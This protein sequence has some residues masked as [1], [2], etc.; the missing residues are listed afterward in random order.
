MPHHRRIC[1]TSPT[2][3]GKSLMMREII[4]RLELPTVLY[5]NRRMLIEQLSTGM[6]DDGI[7]YGIRAAG[8]RPAFL[9]DVQISSLQTEHSRVV[10]RKSWSLHEAKLVMV[11][12]AHGQKQATAQEIL[13]RHVSAGAT[14]IGFTATP[15]DIGEMYDHLIVAGVNSELRACGAHV[16]CHTHAPDEPETKNL[17]RTPTGEYTEGDVK[18][19]IMTPTIVGRVFDWWKRLNPDARPAILFAPGVAESLYFAQ[20]FY[21]RGVPA[22]H[23]DGDEIWINGTLMPADKEARKELAQASESGEVKIVCNRFVMR[24]GIDWPWLYHC[25]MATVFGSLTSYLQS[26]GRLLRSHPSLDHVL[27]QD[28]GGNWWRHGSL[29]A[30]REWDL[31]QT[32]YI[33][34]SMREERI[35]EKKEPEPLTCPECGLVRGG[36][37]R[38]PGCGF[39][40]TKRVRRVVQLDGTLNSVEGD[41]LNP[42]RVKLKPD[43]QQLWDRMYYRARKAGM[44]FRQ[45]QALFFLENFYYPPNNLRLMPVRE[46]D[47]YRKAGEISPTEMH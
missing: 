14:V 34:S 39:E 20:E 13:G 44:T 21:K 27:L 16:I 29:N 37:P 43:T 1:L 40:H 18:K 35:R 26:G 42:R 22:A 46:I 15:L 17:K 23:I 45:A 5:G 24:E 25:I 7:S 47:W 41:I 9:R 4:R 33:V 2:G 19:V 36:G 11:D 10:K 32:A 31:S 38:C 30:D 3:G 28:H 6:D 8:H 12:E